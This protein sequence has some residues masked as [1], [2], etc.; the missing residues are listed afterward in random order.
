MTAKAVCRE[1]AWRLG[2]PELHAR[3]EGVS[4]MRGWKSWSC[5]PCL[6][7]LVVTLLRACFATEGVLDG[8]AWACLP[9][10]LTFSLPTRHRRGNTNPTARSGACD[11]DLAIGTGLVAG[12]LRAHDAGHTRGVK[13]RNP[14]QSW[15]GARWRGARRALWSASCILD[16]YVCI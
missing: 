11:L 4:R 6:V 10:K 8:E 12:A 9:D 16:A 14:V 15:R 2:R 13:R 7:P 1:S 3:Q 5:D